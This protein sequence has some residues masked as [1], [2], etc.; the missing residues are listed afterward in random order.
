MHSIKHHIQG[1]RMVLAMMPKIGLSIPIEF[2]SADMKH[3]NVTNVAF[4]L[5]QELNFFDKLIDLSNDPLIGLKIGRIY[6]LEAYGMFGLALLTS[7][8]LKSSFTLLEKYG[9]LTYSF[10]SFKTVY[11]GDTC[12]F[13]MTPSV[14][15]LP[16]KLQVFYSDRD[17]SAFILLIESLTKDKA[18]YT[19]A[20]LVHDGQG[21]KQDY[22]DYFGCEVIFNA[23]YNSLS[24][25]L[26][27]VDEEL[28]LHHLDAHNSCV[29]KCK[30]LASQMVQTGGLVESV[31]HELTLKPGYLNDLESVASKLNMSNRTLRRKLTQNGTSCLLYTSPS[32]RD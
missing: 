9:F 17:I 14:L 7:E 26:N 21:V 2:V 20:T 4:N 25:T 6:H 19:K 32:P 15:K 8:T 12:T 28:P 5:H 27:Y 1:I 11:E 16:D 22:I 23:P 31:R 3:S 24:F 10:F 18:Y 13:K 29:D 30:L